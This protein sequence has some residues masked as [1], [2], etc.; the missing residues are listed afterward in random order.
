MADMGRASRGDNRWKRV[1]MSRVVGGAEAANSITA[2]AET[3][4]FVA[5][6][7]NE[8]ERGDRSCRCAVSGSGETKCCK[9]SGA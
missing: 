5:L 7:E 1:K 2:E 8:T 4:T 9:A 6:L 3:I